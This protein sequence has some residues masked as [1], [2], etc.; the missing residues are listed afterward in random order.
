MWFK[1]ATYVVNLPIQL[2]DVIPGNDCYQTYYMEVFTTSL[3]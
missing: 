2:I 3:T 1:I